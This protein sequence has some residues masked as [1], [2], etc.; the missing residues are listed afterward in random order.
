[1]DNKIDRI[2]AELADLRQSYAG[3]KSNYKN[4]SRETS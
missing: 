4:V 1:M 3:Q 2:D